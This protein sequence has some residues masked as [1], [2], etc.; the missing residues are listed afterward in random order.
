MITGGPCAVCGTDKASIWYGKRA[1]DKYC[2][3][4]ECMRAG[5]YLKPKKAKGAAAQ[6][7]CAEMKEEENSEVV[8]TLS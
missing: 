4:A 8:S 2:K 1:G 7:V 3:K 5:G 6:R